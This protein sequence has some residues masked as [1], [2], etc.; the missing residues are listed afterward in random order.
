[1]DSC[2]LDTSLIK[3][4]KMLLQVYMKVA[5]NY[6]SVPQTYLPFSPIMTSKTKL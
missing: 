1:L 4:G 5:I 6:G 3:A 2:D